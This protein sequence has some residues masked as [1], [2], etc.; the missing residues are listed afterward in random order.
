MTVNEYKAKVLELFR[1][2]IATDEEWEEMADAVLECSEG[3][4]S[5]KVEVIDAH[6]LGVPPEK[7]LEGE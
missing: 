7:A 6:V 5:Y 1:G 2:G 3:M 4:S